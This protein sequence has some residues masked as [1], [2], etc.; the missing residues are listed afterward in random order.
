MVV[1]YY[2]FI[3]TQGDIPDKIIHYGEFT[4]HRDADL[5]RELYITNM[6]TLVSNSEY[7]FQV[8]SV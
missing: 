1:M 5:P 8:F 6:S 2:Q 7:I 4:I 3:L